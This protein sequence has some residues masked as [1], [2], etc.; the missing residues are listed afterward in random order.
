MECKVEEAL[1]CV[2]VLNIDIGRETEDRREIV[3]KALDVVRSYVRDDDIRYYDSVIRRT[4]LIVLGKGTKRW[5][6]G[7][8]VEFS[9][10]LLFQCRDRRDAESLD[11]M[12]RGA[13]YFPT[14]HWPVEMMDFVG[15]VKDEVRKMGV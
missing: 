3:R 15:G 7:G 2:K 6:R 11:S 10:P 9:V 8:Q 4:R 13:G 14:F 5:E 12:L 1:N